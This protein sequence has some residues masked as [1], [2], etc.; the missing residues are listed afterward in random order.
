ML[1]Q[2]NTIITTHKFVNHVIAPSDLAMMVLNEYVFEEE[3]DL[4]EKVGC[5]SRRLTH[6]KKTTYKFKYNLFDSKE[7]KEDYICHGKG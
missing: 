3:S 1:L 7:H 2:Y 6:R 5:C 4:K